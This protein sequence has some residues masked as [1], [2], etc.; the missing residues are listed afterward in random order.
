MF[1]FMEG[2]NSMGKALPSYAS[3]AWEVPMLG[4]TIG[5]N[6]DRTVAAHADRDA[7]VD[8]ISGR[9]WTYR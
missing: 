2:S 7:L 3:G 5:D 8:R 9:R 6:L 1:T 4:D